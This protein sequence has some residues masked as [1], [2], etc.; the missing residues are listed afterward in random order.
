MFGINEGEFFRLSQEASWLVQAP[1]GDPG[2][3]VLAAD[4][5]RRRLGPHASGIQD[6]CPGPGRRRL[7]NAVVCCGWADPL[8]RFPVTPKVLSGSLTLTFRAARHETEKTSVF[9]W[10]GR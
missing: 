3:S 4:D 2:F 6:I 5:I 10:G 1:F 8:V 9:L 7:E